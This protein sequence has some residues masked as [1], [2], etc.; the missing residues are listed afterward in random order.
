MSLTG[1]AVRRLMGVS[2]AGALPATCIAMAATGFAS[3]EGRVEPGATFYVPKNVPHQFLNM[4]KAPY[5][6]VVVMI[7]EASPRR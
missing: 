2:A 5:D 7:K 1:T 6:V 3:T 4:G